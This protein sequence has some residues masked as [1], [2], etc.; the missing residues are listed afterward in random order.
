MTFFTLVFSLG[1]SLVGNS[2]VTAIDV[3]FLTGDLALDFV[4]MKAGDMPA[5]DV[6]STYYRK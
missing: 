1:I 3:L 2:I 5:F 4:V 6:L